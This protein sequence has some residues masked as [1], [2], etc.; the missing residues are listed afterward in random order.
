MEIQ[1]WEHTASSRDQDLRQIKLCRF[2]IWSLGSI[3]SLF[4][5]ITSDRATIVSSKR[6]VTLDRRST[7]FTRGSG[8]KS[9]SWLTLPP[10]TRSRR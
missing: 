6:R 3:M 7:G 4:S 10:Q 1:V 2:V 9:E 5:G 8:I